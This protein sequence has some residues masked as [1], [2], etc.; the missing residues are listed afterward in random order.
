MKGGNIVDL[1]IRTFHGLNNY[2]SDPTHS[3]IASRQTG[4]FIVG[5]SRRRRPKRISA[6]LKSGSRMRGSRKI[7]HR[8]MNRSSTYYRK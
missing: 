8:R 5:G 6:K 3:M 7:V 2:N 1:P 4:A